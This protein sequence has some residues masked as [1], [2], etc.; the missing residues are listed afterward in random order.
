MNLQ[1]YRGY[2]EWKGWGRTEFAEFSQDEAAYFSAELACAGRR[3]IDRLSVLELG[4]GNGKF[5]AWSQSVGANYC[6]TE[7]I[8]DLLSAASAAGWKVAHGDGK[9]ASLVPSCGLDLVIALDV[10]EHLALVEIQSKLL[11]IHS[12]MKPG[13]LIIARVP[14]GDSPFA[15]AIQYGDIT[16]KTCL[17]SSAIHQLAW[18]AGFEVLQIRSPVLPLV[19]SGPLGAIRRSLMIAA[20]FLCF[21]FVAS[22]LMAH[23]HAVLTPNLIF[24]LR[25][26]G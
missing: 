4:F 14:S 12:V 3:S 2:R 13:G 10:F 7:V 25:R 19:W 24:V 9:L 16:H 23:R 5:G 22:V 18:A 6:G 20:R 15:R 8:P 11:E 17:G 1:T 26:P 21:K